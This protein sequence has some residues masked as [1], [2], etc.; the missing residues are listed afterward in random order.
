MILLVLTLLVF[1]TW[2]SNHTVW[3]IDI[4]AFQDTIYVG[5]RDL[6]KHYFVYSDFF[7]ALYWYY[8]YYY[9]D[10]SERVC[11]VRSHH[12][13]KKKYALFKEIQKILFVLPYFNFC[14]AW[15]Y[16]CCVSILLKMSITVVMGVAIGL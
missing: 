6:F 5:K 15:E 9:S 10:V 11:W 12:P 1:L 13:R 2:H 7:F 16:C 4:F 8:Y 3:I 14:L